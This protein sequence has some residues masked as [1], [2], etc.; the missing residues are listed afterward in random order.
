MVLAAWRWYTSPMDAETYRLVYETETTHWWYRSRRILFLEQVKA[1]L[2]EVRR[3]ARPRILDFGCGTG[4]NLRHLSDLGDPV[5]A[6]ISPVALTDARRTDAFERIDLRENVDSHLGHYHVATALDVLEHMEDEVA[7]LQRVASFLVPGGQLVLTVP[8]Y[9]W[10]WSG[11]DEISHH[12]RRYTKRRLIKVIDEAG[13][14]IRFLSYFNLSVLPLMA[15]SVLSRR[16][17]HP[18]RW[19]Q[20]PNVANTPRWLNTLL[21]RVTSFE[22]ASVG[23]QRLRLPAGASAI[24]RVRRRNAES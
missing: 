21:T 19:R 13:L 5:G 18:R 20:M 23:R 22:L 12:L 9:K 8:A 17:L 7:G 2:E 16:T 11:E 24:C 14:E 3:V 4:F 10:L 15:L 1:A 6:D